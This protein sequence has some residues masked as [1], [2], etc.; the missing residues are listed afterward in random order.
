M[1]R[2]RFEYF[3]KLLRN[4]LFF[5]IIIIVL[6]AY[7][8]KKT[9]R[10]EVA[11]QI[12]RAALKYIFFKKK[13]PS[14]QIGNIQQIRRLLH[15][16]NFE[17]KILNKDVYGP[18][19]K[20]TTIFVVT[21]NK[22]TIYLEFLIVSLS[23][24]NGIDDALIIFSHLYFDENINNLIQSI[25]FCRVLQLF[26]PYSMQMYPNEFPG[27]QKEDCP[28][29][30]LIEKAEASNCTGAYTPDIHGRYRNPVLV[31]K[32]H[33]WWWTANMVFETLTFT[34]NYTGNVIFL[35]DD[36]YL[37]HDSIYMILFMKRL[38]ETLNLGE[39]MSLNAVPYSIDKRDDSYRV[40][41]MSWDPVNDP[42]VFA[43]DAAVWNSIASHY[44][45]FCRIDDYSW[46][47]SLYYVSLNRRDGIQFRM[48]SSVIPR[49]FKTSMCGLSGYL[50]DCDVIESVYQVLHLQKELA[51][52][53]FPPHLEAYVHVEM[54]DEYSSFDYAWSNGGFNDPR[55]KQFCVNVTRS[56]IKKA[57]LD[58]R[59]EFTNLRTD[60]M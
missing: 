33:H 16:Y 46:A 45:M 59:K 41:V 17:E 22:L 11:T 20:D 13:D 31:E 42:D 53:L 10:R 23:Q 5:L 55:D 50:V 12:P 19:K 44:D 43:L 3:L 34:K 9:H 25:D 49:A 35:K 6:F 37:L 29:D 60:E 1:V 30:M 8:T 15:R 38:S 51:E 14:S 40:E 27:Y 24:V 47:R 54:E 39:F 48:M 18:I 7:K 52:D 26:Y 32:K 28:H 58:M 36:L 21:V 4:V 56:K 2:R 57:L